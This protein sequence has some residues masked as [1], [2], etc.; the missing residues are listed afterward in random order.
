MLPDA[1]DNGAGSPGLERARLTAAAAGVRDAQSALDASVEHLENE[2]RAAR[3]NGMAWSKIS[4]MTGRTETQ[5]AWILRQ[6]EKRTSTTKG[7]T[8]S[9]QGTGV[10]VTEYARTEGVTRRTVYLWAKKGYVQTTENMLGQM[11]ILGK[12]N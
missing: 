8:R 5:L 12:A 4:S 10:S 6:G 9:G 2:V 3:N 1:A 11:R 7:T